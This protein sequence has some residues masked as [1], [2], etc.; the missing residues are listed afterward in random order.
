MSESKAKVRASSPDHFAQD[1]PPV[2]TIELRVEHLSQ[3]FD[4][5][6]PFPF[7]ERDLDPEAEAY[8]VNWAR[9]LP[10][11]IPLAIIVQM[12][13][14]EAKTPEAKKLPDAIRHYFETRA[15]RK[16]AEK[17][18][19]FRIGRVYLAIGIAALVVCLSASQLAAAQFGDSAFSAFL[20]EGL[21][22]V[23]WVANWKP[24][25]I[26]LYDWWPLVRARRLHLRLATAHVACKSY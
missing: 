12:P 9:E 16:A 26:F 2:G 17:K 20:E 24:L 7:A 3:M 1:A 23:G 13:S 22:I 11:G 10:R 21:I 4:T 14:A 8:I 18:D 6:D 25:E 15:A 19:L 5:L